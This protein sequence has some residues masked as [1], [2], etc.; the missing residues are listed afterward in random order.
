MFIAHSRSQ[1][2]SIS[3]SNF[4]FCNRFKHAVTFHPESYVISFKKSQITSDVQVVSLIK[5]LF[6][7]KR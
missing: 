6:V 3:K 4:V 2:L 1:Q 5:T 7:T